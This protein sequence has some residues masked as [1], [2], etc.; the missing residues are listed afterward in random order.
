LLLMSAETLPG[1]KR[2]DNSD[3]GMLS[4]N[5]RITRWHVRD[6]GESW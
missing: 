2:P 3:L 4:E 1:Q 5:D 6:A